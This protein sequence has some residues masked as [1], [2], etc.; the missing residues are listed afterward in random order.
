MIRLATF[1]HPRLAQAFIDYMAFRGIDIQLGVEE[2][3]F[4]LWLPKIEDQVEAE[5]ELSAFLHDPLAAKYQSASW[6]MAES[7]TAKFQYT[8]VSLWQKIKDQAGVFTLGIMGVSIAFY[9]LSLLGF[10][11]TL[12]SWFLFPSDQDKAW[13]LWRFFSHAVL[14]FSLLHIL[15]NLLWWWLLGGKIEKQ[16]GSSKLVQIFLFSALVSGLAQYLVEGANFGGLSGVVY[17]LLG[18]LWLLKK[19]APSSCVEIEQAYIG[20]ML[21]WLVIGFAEPFGMAIANMAHLFG[22]LT[23]MLLGFADGKRKNKSF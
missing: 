19:T 12:L 4:V 8:S 2:D 22:L 15:F 7:R 5:A 18:Y 3:E 17:A 23:G 1:K 6:D 9:L 11:S 13:Q 14:H 16:L 21:I 20:F 10:S